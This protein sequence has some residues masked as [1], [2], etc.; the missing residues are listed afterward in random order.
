MG[1]EHVYLMAKLGQCTNEVFLL[2]WCYQTKASE[3][4]N[5]LCSSPPP[6]PDQSAVKIQ[7]GGCG[8]QLGL[9]FAQQTQT[10]PGFG[11]TYHTSC[12]E[13]ALRVKLDCDWK[14]KHVA[15]NGLTAMLDIYDLLYDLLIMASKLNSFMTVDDSLNLHP[16]LAS[17]QFG[18][19]HHAGTTVN[20][21]ILWQRRGARTPQ[22]Y[23]QMW[24]TYFL[25]FKKK[26]LVVGS[27]GLSMSRSV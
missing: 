3:I 25:L 24:G 7:R 13:L 17:L 6:I 19:L 18:N 4:R 21:A 5:L 22:S 27:H 10:L 26:S 8:C 23:S 2:L 1:F 11:W 9:P 12:S 15:W 14:L 20:T 16:E